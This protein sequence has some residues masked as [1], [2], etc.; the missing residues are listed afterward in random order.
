MNLAPTKM[1]PCGVRW[2]TKITMLTPIDINGLIT[3]INLIYYFNY[4]LFVFVKYE[5]QQSNTHSLF[6]ILTR[7]NINRTK[8][9]FAWTPTFMIARDGS[10]HRH[11][12]TPI[13]H[14]NSVEEIFKVSIKMVIHSFMSKKDVIV[15]ERKMPPASDSRWSMKSRFTVELVKSMSSRP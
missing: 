10:I 15:K 5:T 14:S 1:S 7:I 13:R 3:E 8:L 12:N 4:N 6:Y 11:G 2:I 9:T